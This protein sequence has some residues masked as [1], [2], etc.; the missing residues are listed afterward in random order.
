MRPDAM[1]RAIAIAIFCFA[2]MPARADDTP[3]FIAD[4][5]SHCSVGTYHPEPAL[6]VH[7]SG[8]CVAGKAEGQGVA[9]WQES[10]QLFARL[11]GPFHAGLLEGRGL[12]FVPGG[13]RFEAEFRGG[14]MNGRCIMTAPQGRVD[15]QC[16]NDQLNGPGKAVFPDGDRY[17]GDFKDSAITGQGIWYHA[18]GA[19]QE[20]EWLD[21]KLNGKGRAIYASG[22]R[23][24]GDYVEGKYEGQGIY[25]FADGNVY[26]G[27]WANDL[28]NGRGVLHGITHGLMGEGH[29][30]YIGTWVNGCFHQ[31]PYTAELFKTR[32]EC[33]FD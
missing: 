4:P 28:P 9:E 29:H 11:E 21:A 3:T 20:G 5:T 31:E 7:W 1:R 17:E 16:A 13:V 23:Y 15:G 25:Y 33:G 10:G 2:A 12:R 22:D 24:E 26:E 6:T 8:A 18:N 14:R 32:A 27:E 19:R 30:D